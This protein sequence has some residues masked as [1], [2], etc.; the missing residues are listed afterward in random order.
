MNYESFVKKAA[1]AALAGGAAY[2]SEK[3]SGH[4]L[5]VAV[6]AASVQVAVGEVDDL[7]EH[8]RADAGRLKHAAKPKAKQEEAVE[9]P[10]D[11][12]SER[13]S[14]AMGLHH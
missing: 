11:C 12:Q 1:A 6:I 3:Y 9:P 4:L 14:H 7:A 8:A 2:L 5:D 13:R 10:I